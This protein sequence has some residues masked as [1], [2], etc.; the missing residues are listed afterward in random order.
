MT[1]FKAILAAQAI[2]PVLPELLD[3]ETAAEIDRKLQTL[4]THF[5]HVTHHKQPRLSHFR[6]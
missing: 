1:Q 5:A 4:L 6:Q 3:P 2:R